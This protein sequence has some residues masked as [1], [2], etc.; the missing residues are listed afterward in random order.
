MD[1]RD[2]I[3]KLDAIEQNKLLAEAESLLEREGLRL[4]DIEQAV[5]RELDANKRAQIL[6][7]MAKKYGYSGLFDPNTGKF[8]NSDGKFATIGAYQVEV[9]RLADD[10]LIPSSAK[11]SNWGMGKDEKEAKPGSFKMQDLLANVDKADDLLDKALNGITLESKGIA[12]SLLSEFGINTQLLEAITPQEHQF[13]KQTV[14]AADSIKNRNPDAKSLIVRY[15][16]EY[17]PARNRLIAKIKEVIAAIKPAKSVATPAATPDRKGAA[18]TNESSINESELLFELSLTPQGQKSGAKLY[19][20]SITGYLSPEQVKHNLAL[21]KKGHAKLDWS[22]HV[23]KTVKDWGNMA[24]FDLLDKFVAGASSAFD[25]NTT[26]KRER[27]KQKIIDKFYDT[28][29][30]A[31][32]VRGIAGN[33]GFKIGADNPVGNMTVGDVLGLVGPG[34]IT[35]VFN[36]GTKV[37]TKLGMGTVGRIATGTGAVY[38]G[39][40]ASNAI[41]KAAGVDPREPAPSPAPG[42]NNNTPVTPQPANNSKLKYDPEVKKIQDYLV[43]VYGGAKNILPK[44]DAD[45]KLGT[46]TR[47]AI[48]RA[49]KDGKLT[50]DGKIPAKTADAAT[51]TDNNTKVDDPALKTNAMADLDPKV[52]Q[53]ALKKLG[54]TGPEISPEQLLALADALGIKEDDA[55]ADAGTGTEPTTTV[56]SAGTTS[57]AGSGGSSG[58]SSG[59]GGGGLTQGTT[60]TAESLELSRIRALSGL[61]DDQLDENAFAKFAPWVF[62]Q[63]LA[64]GMSREAQ[65]ASMTPTRLTPAAQKAEIAAA[66]KIAARIE[67]QGQKV[68][69]GAEKVLPGAEKVLPGAEKVLPGV[70]KVVP[71]VEKVVPKFVERLRGLGGRFVRLLKNPKFLAILA[72]LAGLGIYLATR[73]NKDDSVTPMPVDPNNRVDPAPAP[74]PAPAPG[75]DAKD[76]ERKKQLADLEKLLAQLVGGWPTDPE[77]AETVQAAVAVGAKAPEGFNPS[78]AVSPQ[79]ATVSNASSGENDARRANSMFGGNAAGATTDQLIN[80]TDQKKTPVAA[81]SNTKVALSQKEMSDIDMAF[82]YPSLAKGEVKKAYDNATPEKRAAVKAYLDSKGYDAKKTF[83]IDF[84]A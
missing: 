54:I 8:V 74:A 76:E 43:Q 38:A 1:L 84:S 35:S 63:M 40:K 23:G 15:N 13:L 80:G 73:D 33:M 25:P 16:K 34:L 56:A 79:P 20:P 19:T 67:A 62:D 32:N 46:E 44:Y 58:G 70:E 37:A 41:D 69:P 12:E 71:G 48:A 77:T 68:V 57:S 14:Q 65:L 55:V 59:G 78:G 21:V 4:S 61:T 28:Q 39:Q 53:D 29:K 30:G 52:V 36:A 50:A 5:G 27:E 7:Q 6:G 26:Y 49:I 47:T 64:K 18:A 10:G 72:V 51:T 17:V 66:K 82:Q 24:S 9:E 60:A 11:T 81:A 75:P 2:L 45:G 3:S 31:A 83:G 42:P 22:D